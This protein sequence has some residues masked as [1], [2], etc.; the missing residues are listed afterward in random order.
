MLKIVE[1]HLLVKREQ[2]KFPRSKKKRI[3][4]KWY[5]DPKNWISY[6]DPAVYKSGNTIF[7]HPIMASRIKAAMREEQ[8]NAD[9]STNTFYTPYEYVR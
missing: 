5:K 2:I 4:K 8:A 3:L 1:N 7:C 9:Y 6:P